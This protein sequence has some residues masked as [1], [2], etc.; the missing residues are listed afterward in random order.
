MKKEEKGMNSRQGGRE[1]GKKD[2]EEEGRRFCSGR[3]GI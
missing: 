3:S 2:E 1:R